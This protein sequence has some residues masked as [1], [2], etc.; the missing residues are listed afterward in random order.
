M[1]NLIKY[2]FLIFFI[3]QT[4]VSK[5]EITNITLM[6][7]FDDQQNIVHFKSNDLLKSYK[8]DK[9]QKFHLFDFTK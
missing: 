6:E 3:H 2:L 5:A 9:D 4:S 7:Q 8:L 1:N